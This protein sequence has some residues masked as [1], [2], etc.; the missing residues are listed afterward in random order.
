MKF[1]FLGIL[2][3]SFCFFSTN[4]K[5]QSKKELIKTAIRTFESGKNEED[6]IKQ[7][8]YFKLAISF[9]E[10]ADYC[11]SEPH[12]R[13]GI[14]DQLYG[15]VSK[16]KSKRLENYSKAI[17]H[18][19][20]AISCPIS[21][22]SH[23]LAAKMYAIKAQ[24]HFDLGEIN[25]AYLHCKTALDFDIDEHISNC[26]M[27][28]VFAHKGYYETAIDYYSRAIH[29]H[30]ESRTYYLHRGIAWNK[31]GNQEKAIEDI[32]V[33]NRLN[34][35]VFEQISPSKLHLYKA[36][37]SIGTPIEEDNEPP[38]LC[39]IA[40]FLKT[41][42]LSNYLTS[43]EVNIDSLFKEFRP[44]ISDFEILFEGEVFEEYYTKYNQLYQENSDI[45]A[46]KYHNYEENCQNIAALF[47]DWQTEFFGTYPKF[48]NTH[49]ETAIFTFYQNFGGISLTLYFFE[50]ESRDKIVIFDLTTLRQIAQ[51]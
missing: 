27:G 10:S 28:R 8:S 19:D 9:A 24:L 13:L 18:I 21:D 20:D 33:A 51:D 42:V 36:F 29:H 16:D 23:E 34:S 35:G 50:I 49:T 40:R 22:E 2:I 44:S 15:H 5:A 6:L 39:T 41:Y 32:E 46:F 43:N 7:A 26:L 38:P 14:I 47:E 30:P 37:D 3:F 25:T 1:R 48:R 31:M 45:A 17:S 12:F 11:Y 4:L